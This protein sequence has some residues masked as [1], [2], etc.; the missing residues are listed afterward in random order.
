MKVNDRWLPLPEDAPNAATT[1]SICKGKAR[2]HPFD[3]GMVEIIA[4][5]F[6]SPNLNASLGEAAFEQ[7]HVPLLATSQSVAIMCDQDPHP[8]VV[9]DEDS[10]LRIPGR[11][12]VLNGVGECMEHAGVVERCNIHAST[13]AERLRE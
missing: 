7:L 3:D 9:P 4:R 1:G 10:A 13:C 11:D 2:N 12:G 5:L 6:E 8:L